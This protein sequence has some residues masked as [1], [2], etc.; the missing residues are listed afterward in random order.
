MLKIEDL[1]KLINTDYQQRKGEYPKSNIPDSISV[2][3]TPNK[4]NVEFTFKNTSEDD[5]NNWYEKSKEF[6]NS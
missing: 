2:E 3:I 1:K 4:T 6:K 5:A